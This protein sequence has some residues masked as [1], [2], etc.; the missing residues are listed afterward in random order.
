MIN[1]LGA[2]R[3]MG[4][5]LVRTGRGCPILA[6]HPTAWTSFDPRGGK[7]GDFDFE[8]FTAKTNP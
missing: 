4:V 2:K 8:A 6:A 5:S 3:V 7:A 1:D